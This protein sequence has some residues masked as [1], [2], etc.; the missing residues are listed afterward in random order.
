MCFWGAP[1]WV[2]RRFIYMYTHIY[3][4]S[5]IEDPLSV[6]A[7][8]CQ[9]WIWKCNKHC[10]GDTPWGGT[11]GRP[12]WVG[13]WFMYRYVCT[14]ICMYVCTHRGPPLCRGSVLSKLNIKVEQKLHRADQR[15]WRGPWGSHPEFAKGHTY[16]KPPWGGS[17]GWTEGIYTYVYTNICMY[18]CTHTYIYVYVFVYIYVYICMCI[19]IY[20]Y[21]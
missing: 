5:H 12:P 2:G 21:I 7:V 6:G 13:R 8:Y 16:M 11:P 9:G 1:P 20:V 17:P 14:H 18:V 19:Y 10:I 4:Y 15:P 3:V